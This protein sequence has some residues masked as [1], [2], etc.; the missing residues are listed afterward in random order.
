MNRY[1]TLIANLDQRIKY[2]SKFNAHEIV[3]DVSLLYHL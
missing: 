1:L 3:I 2:A